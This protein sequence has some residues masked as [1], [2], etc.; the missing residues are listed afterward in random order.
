MKTK[1]KKITIKKPVNPQKKPVELFHSLTLINTNTGHQQTFAGL[2]TA[3]FLNHVRVASISPAHRARLEDMAA[4]A[5]ASLDTI[6]EYRDPPSVRSTETNPEGWAEFKRYC[7]ADRIDHLARLA[8][9]YDTPGVPLV[10]GADVQRDGVK[11]GA[12][13]REGVMGRQIG[14]DHYRKKLIQ[15]WDVIDQSMTRDQ[16]IGYY[17]GNVLKYSMRWQD[18][19]GEEDLR[20]M[21]H[22][23]QKL[24]TVLDE[25]PQ[26]T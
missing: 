14:G 7:S 5:S 18:K 26:S 3:D 21:A 4:G 2:T 9:K 1:A 16:R 19:G 25:K 10:A 8:A 13:Q 17:N 24:I 20:K 6:I 15:P 22:Y 23:A 11:V 12:P